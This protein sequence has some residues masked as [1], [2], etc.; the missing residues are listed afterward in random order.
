MNILSQ[1]IGDWRYL[2]T[3]LQ[4]YTVARRRGFHF[5]L[6]LY[7]MQKSKVLGILMISLAI[8]LM[9]LVAGYAVIFSIFGIKSGGSFLMITPLVVI[10]SAMI[11]V[12][13]FLLRAGIRQIK[14]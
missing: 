1:K 10:A 5:N 3:I 4:T 13:S 8:L 2:Y 6:K 12:L 7:F 9:I 11:I 14:N